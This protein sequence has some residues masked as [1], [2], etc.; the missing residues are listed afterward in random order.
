VIFSELFRQARETEM[1]TLVS[2]NLSEFDLCNRA[3]LGLP[4][5]QNTAVRP[6]ASAV[7]LADHRSDNFSVTGQPGALATDNSNLRIFGRQAK[8]FYRLIKVAPAR[9]EEG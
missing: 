8:R 3:I 6:A 2:L 9:A 1:V 4:V 7:I 5:P